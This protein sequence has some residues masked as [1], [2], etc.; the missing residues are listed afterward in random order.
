MRLR[1]DGVDVEITVRVALVEDLRAR[2]GRLVG[3]RD[4]DKRNQR[5]TS[6]NRPFM[7]EL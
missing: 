2:G 5:T 4:R 6:P 7:T 3:G 1:V